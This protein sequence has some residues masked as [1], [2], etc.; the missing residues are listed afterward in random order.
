MTVIYLL[1]GAIMIA[2]TAGV[3]MGWDHLRDFFVSRPPQA[4]DADREIDKEKRN[5]AITIEDSRD[6][7]DDLQA[8]IRGVLADHDRRRHQHRMGDG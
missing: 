7:S 3:F 6:A 8:I 2:T 1:I 5:F 4:T